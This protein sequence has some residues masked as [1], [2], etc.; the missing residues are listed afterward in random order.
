MGVMLVNKAD[1]V[2][3][4]IFGLCLSLFAWPVPV[5]DKKGGDPDFVVDF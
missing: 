1:G 3:G 5:D 2:S 4:V